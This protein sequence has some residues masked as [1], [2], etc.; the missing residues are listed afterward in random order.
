MVSLMIIVFYS[1]A[2][3]RREFHTAPLHC[4]GI[5]GLIFGFKDDKSTASECRHG[6]VRS[7]KVEWV[8]GHADWIFL[9]IKNDGI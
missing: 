8:K 9:G 2:K 1:K 7:L 4:V 6:S 5:V 3:S